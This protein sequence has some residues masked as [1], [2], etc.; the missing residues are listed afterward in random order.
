MA[1]ENDSVRSAAQT[2]VDYAI[3]CNLIGE[4]DR[5]WAYNTVLDCVGA[6]G[7]RPITYKQ[8]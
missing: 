3:A 6:Q 5:I 4:A 8:R 2:L 7:L 1:L